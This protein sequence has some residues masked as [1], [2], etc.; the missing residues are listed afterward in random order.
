M[1]VKTEITTLRDFQAWAGAKD[2]LQ[3]VL[4][5]GKMDE[6]DALVEELFYEPVDETILNDFL[7]FDLSQNY[8]E[9]LSSNS[10]EE[11]A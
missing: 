5:N 1:V 10:E 2:N 6:L 11:E 3:T 7:W 4:E 8:P 9:L